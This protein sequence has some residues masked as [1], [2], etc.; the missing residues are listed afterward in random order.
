VSE[1]ELREYEARRSRILE[2]YYEILEP[3]LAA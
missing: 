2:L 1:P 3:R